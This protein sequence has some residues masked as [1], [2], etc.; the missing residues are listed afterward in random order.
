[1]H[2]IG[3]DRC[4]SHRCG[5]VC[6]SSVCISSVCIGVHLIGVHLIGV[7]L[8]GVHRCASAQVQP[9]TAG[10][11]RCHG[12]RRRAQGTIALASL[13]PACEGTSVPQDGL[14]VLR[15]MGVSLHAA[16]GCVARA[17]LLCR[18]PQERKATEKRLAS[19]RTVLEGADFSEATLHCPLRY[20]A[21]P[22]TIVPLCRVRPRRARPR[23]AGRWGC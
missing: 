11:A 22:V 14:H 15:Y 18:P 19:L 16:R 23:G 1:M 7:H 13:P 3:V 17:T 21:A 8:I 12:L 10:R 5:S 4:A 2:L 6:I 9:S 20:S